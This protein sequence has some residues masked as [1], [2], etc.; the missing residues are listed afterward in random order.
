MTMF[1][2]S[3]TGWQPSNKSP[4]THYGLEKKREGIFFFFGKICKIV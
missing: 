2:S 4:A 1:L 3:L